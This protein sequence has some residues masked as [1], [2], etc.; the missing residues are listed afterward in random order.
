MGPTIDVNGEG[1]TFAELSD[2]L[3]IDQESIAPPRVPAEASWLRPE[4]LYPCSHEPS[5][6]GPQDHG[7]G[8]CRCTRRRRPRDCRTEPTRAARWLAR[9]NPRPT[10]PPE[11][12]AR[13][14]SGTRT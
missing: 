2:F 10:R 13:P 11:G 3:T 7:P 8:G 5:I 6:G 12:L 1:L 4:E 14:P 9:C